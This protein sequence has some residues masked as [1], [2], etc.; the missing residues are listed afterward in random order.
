V[1]RLLA[2]GRTRKE[3]AAELVIATSTADRHINHICDKLGVRNRVEAVVLGS[4]ALAEGIPSPFSPRTS[5]RT[6]I[7]R[8]ALGR[9]R[10]S[11]STERMRHMQTLRWWLRIVGVFYVLQFVLN[12]IVHAPISTVGPKSALALASAGDR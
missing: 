8:M 6:Q 7:S 9:A 2:R 4:M 1:L 10:R 11:V 5:T 3:I 12:A